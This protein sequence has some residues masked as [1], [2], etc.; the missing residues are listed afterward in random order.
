LKSVDIETIYRKPSGSTLSIRHCHSC[1]RNFQLFIWPFTVAARACEF[2]FDR[3]SYFFLKYFKSKNEHY[4]NDVKPIFEAW[5]SLG[6]QPL[7][8]HSSSRGREFENL[9]ITASTDLIQLD[10]RLMGRSHLASYNTNLNIILNRIGEYNQN[11]N[12]FIQDFD[13]KTRQGIGKN[14]P[15]LQEYD[16]SLNQQSNFYHFINIPYYIW[17][18]FWE[19]R[20]ESELVITDYDNRV[21]E[22]R[23][24]PGKELIARS[25]DRDTISRL[26]E[27]IDNITIDIIDTL[28]QF[29]EERN[30]LVYDFQS[31]TA[32]VRDV[33][34]NIAW[35]KPFKGKCGWEKG[36]WGFKVK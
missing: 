32:S 2:G 13:T 9:L 16:S 18:E 6:I 14:V 4:N 35:N 3:N 36:F 11:I 30:T 19:E 21:H 33:L 25:E 17:T 34:D 1:F 29:K 20:H 10:P 27:Y 7:E 31:F 28:S 5:S 12:N 24:L 8:F 15:S 22:L 26:K 23:K